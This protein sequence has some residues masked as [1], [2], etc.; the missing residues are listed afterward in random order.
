MIRASTPDDTVAIVDVWLAA[1]RESHDFVPYDV[2]LSHAD[3]MREVYLPSSE[4]YVATDSA[5]SVIGFV[6]L[7]GNELAALFVEP[8]HQGCGIGRSLLLHAQA[9]R[10]ILTLSVYVNNARAVAFYRSH[11]FR[12]QEERIDQRTGQ[13]ETCM[14]WDA[15]A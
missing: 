10:E 1:S 15:A 12:P 7:A 13:R 11:G 8:S 5:G 6:S 4:T 2:W 14:R 3:A 9:K